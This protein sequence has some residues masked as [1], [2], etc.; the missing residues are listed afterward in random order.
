MIYNKNKINLNFKLYYN[1]ICFI[2]VD[3]IDNI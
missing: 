1:T 3:N 2:I